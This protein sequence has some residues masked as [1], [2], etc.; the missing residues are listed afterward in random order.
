MTSFSIGD[1]VHVKEEPGIVKFVGP[2]T[3]APGNWVGVELD[4]PTGKN[5][6]TVQGTK[7]FDCRQEGNYG[8]FVRPNFLSR[9][10]NPKILQPHELLDAEKIV[11]RLQDKLKV[12]REEISQNKNQIKSLQAELDNK[13]AQFDDL[14]IKLEGVVVDQNYL[15]D[16]NSSLREQLELLQ[17]KYKDIS[18]DYAILQEE[19]EL[20]KELELAVQSQVSD[21]GEVTDDDVKVLVQR[22]KKLEVALQALQ[23]LSS[24]REAY[25][26]EEISTLGKHGTDITELRKS[27][28]AIS[29][30]LEEAE[31]TVEQLQEQLESVSALDLVIEHLT[32]ENEALQA[33]VSELSKTVAELTELNELNTSL[34]EYQLNV[35]LELKTQIETLLLEIQD[36]KDKFSNLSLRNEELLRTID[37]IKSR[38]EPATQD[39]SGFEQLVLDVKK[40]SALVKQDKLDLKATSEELRIKDHLIEMAIPNSISLKFQVLASLQK[41]I[42][43]CDLVNEYFKETASIQSLESYL[44]LV[45]FRHYASIL[46]SLVEYSGSLTNISWEE[47]KLAATD[48]SQGMRETF[49]KVKNDDVEILNLAFVD[50]AILDHPFILERVNF[51]ALN[52]AFLLL[53]LAKQA[54]ISS[55]VIKRIFGDFF[56]TQ[57]ESSNIIQSLKDLQAVALRVSSRAQALYDTLI[58][59]Y[60]LSDWEVSDASVVELNSL[61]LELYFKLREEASSYYSEEQVPD[62]LISLIGET[63]SRGLHLNE[64]IREFEETLDSLAADLTRRDSGL[65][66]FYSELLEPSSPRAQDKGDSGVSDDQPIEELKHNIELLEKNMESIIKTGGATT[67]ELQTQISDAKREFMELQSLYDALKKENKAIEA[68][69]EL[70]LRSNT[71]ASHH[72]VPFF[73][74]LKAKMKYTNELALI[75]EISLLKEMVLCGSGS[76]ADSADDLEWLMIPLYNNC[77]SPGTANAR[78]FA[79]EARC[80]RDQAVRLL[81]GLRDRKIRGA[82]MIANGVLY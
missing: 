40:L 26:K 80:Q 10:T 52:K 6:G 20:N 3:F 29:A 75:E 15:K 82:G 5:N 30:K 74:D 2:T 46:V 16:R 68:E 25:L 64:K 9:T 70:V 13:S 31:A 53:D 49:E 50:K 56:S 73:E 76:K 17:G 38:P 69:L 66:S 7:Y 1:R 4:T 79:I 27:Y 22:N 11:I 60:Y 43:E 12:A 48:L 57:Q 18:A 24:D 41:A 42:S 72:Q 65:K 62:K 33:K 32:R 55:I 34:E 35:E 67:R 47:L 77:G 63:V 54:G 14:E 71:I 39:S 8:V 61:L 19:A 45:H 23:T 44:L 58:K 36:W 51:A 59:H 28:D 78:S 21:G 37:D 81:K